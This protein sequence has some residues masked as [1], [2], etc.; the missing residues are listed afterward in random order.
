MKNKNVL[1]AEGRCEKNVHKKYV[2]RWAT[3]LFAYYSDNDKEARKSK[4]EC[5]YCYYIN[6]ARVGGSAMTVKHCESCD[7]KMLFS[8]TNTDKLCDKCSDELGLCKHCG[9]KIE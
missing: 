5:K 7:E 9:Q 3:Q 1:M 2:E 6:F 4:Q 8:S